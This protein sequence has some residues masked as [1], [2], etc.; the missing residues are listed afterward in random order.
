MIMKIKLLIAAIIVILIL[1]VG[2]YLYA[3][4]SKQVQPGVYN[5]TQ[6]SI[7]D[8]TSNISNELYQLP[9]D[10]DLNKDVNALSQEVESF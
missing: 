5:Y 2:W 3:A 6:P 4:Y 1:I 10:T 9:S 8:T 7:S